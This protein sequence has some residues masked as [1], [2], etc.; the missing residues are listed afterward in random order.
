[1]RCCGH[2][3]FCTLLAILCM[4]LLYYHSFGLKS[5]A[6]EVQC[7]THACMAEVVANGSSLRRG[8]DYVPTKPQTSCAKL[9]TLGLLHLRSR[10]D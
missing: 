8:L 9:R 7:C 1:M 5:T 3:I 4:L 10:A 2:E 6:I